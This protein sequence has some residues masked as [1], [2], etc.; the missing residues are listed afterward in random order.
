[1]QREVSKSWLRWIHQCYHASEGPLP[2][3]CGRCG[4]ECLRR[5]P[6][7]GIGREQKVLGFPAHRLSEAQDVTAV[8]DGGRLGRT[9]AVG[10]QVECSR[11]RTPPEEMSSV[12]TSGLVRS[13]DAR[14]RIYSDRRAG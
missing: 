14:S 5:Q 1:M 10:C 13:D 11:I 4:D 7:I 9:I 3:A 6:S 12:V 2:S 8:V